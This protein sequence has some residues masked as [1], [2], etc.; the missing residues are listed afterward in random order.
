ME[1]LT[2]ESELINKTILEV[3]NLC[4][5]IALK[6]TDNTYAI[7]ICECSYEHDFSI[8]IESNTPTIYEKREI[9]IISEQ[10]YLQAVKNQITKYSENKKQQDLALLKSL[11]EKYEGA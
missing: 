11:K 3:I 10:E 7:I 9:G 6:F 5:K 8:I 4:D 2:T 1:Q